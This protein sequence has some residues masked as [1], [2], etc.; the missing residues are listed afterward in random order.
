[1]EKKKNIILTG[2][3][4]VIL[5][6]VYNLAVFLI[7]NKKTEVFWLSYGFMAA[8]FIFQLVSMAL[9]FKNTSVET[10]FFG[11]PLVSL[12]VFYLLAELFCSLI[13]MIFQGAGIKA[14]LLVQALLLAAFAVIAIISLMSRDAVQDI[15]SKISENVSFIRSIQVDIEMLTARCDDAELKASLKKLAETVKY[16]DP[17]TNDAV[18]GVES[19]IMQRLAE[20]KDYFD[21]GQYGDANKVCSEMELLFLERNKKLMI[22]K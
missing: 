14:A 4:Y 20:I 6:A 3:I 13:F 18:A 17:M 12:S 10:I 15:S 11:I 9:A 2:M 21:I 19:R 8:A 1:M 22:S 16:S 5:F 7:F